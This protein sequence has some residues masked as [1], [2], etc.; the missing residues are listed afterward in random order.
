MITF[1]IKRKW[2]ENGVPQEDTD[3]IHH[4]RDLTEVEE[5]SMTA[6]LQRVNPQAKIEVVRAS[7]QGEA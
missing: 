3:T 2:V 7:S 4:K 1:I 6:L 5:R